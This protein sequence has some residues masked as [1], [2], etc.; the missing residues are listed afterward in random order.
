MTYRYSLVA[1]AAMLV[2]LASERLS[3]Q[4]R[5]YRLGVNAAEFHE[6]FNAASAAME[7]EVRASKKGCGAGVKIAC[8]YFVNERIGIIA[9]AEKNDPRATEIIVMYSKASAVDALLFMMTESAVISAITPSADRRELGNFL[10]SLQK[11]LLDQDEA[12]GVF[13]SVHYTLTKVD[14]MLIFGAE[15]PSP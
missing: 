9:S 12:D 13:N 11:R 8:Q 4:E 7:F 10:T 1:L 2:T 6:N 5:E 14:S 3:A 15:P